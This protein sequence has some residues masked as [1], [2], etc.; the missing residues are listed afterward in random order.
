MRMK[1][2]GAWAGG[3]H[4]RNRINGGSAT[5]RL[6]LAFDRRA[7]IV[8]DKQMGL[9]IKRAWHRTGA[10][11]I[12]VKSNWLKSICCMGRAPYRDNS[13]WLR[14]YMAAVESKIY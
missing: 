3:F 6:L 9:K 4:G 5:N 12:A 10:Q 7:L 8:V 13:R 14:V 1:Y 2:L 11:A